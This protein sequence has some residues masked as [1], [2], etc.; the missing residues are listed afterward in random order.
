MSVTNFGKLSPTNNADTP[1]NI[2]P[3]FFIFCLILMIQFL[4]N[5]LTSFGCFV[6]FSFVSV[7]EVSV[8]LFSSSELL[9]SSW[10]SLL[11]NPSKSFLY[12]NIFIFIYNISFGL[13]LIVSISLF[14]SLIY[15]CILYT[16][17]VEALICY[18]WLF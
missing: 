2:L 18:S 17:S 14:T 1:M 3:L 13:F 8:D 9:S 5:Y 10:S 4:W 15:P 7:E 6:H 16:F 12:P 11:M